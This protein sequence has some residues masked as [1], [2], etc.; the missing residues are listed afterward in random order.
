MV[1]SPRRPPHLCAPLLSA[2]IRYVEASAKSGRGSA[3]AFHLAV[4]LVRRGRVAEAD[5]ERKLKA[6]KGGFL[7]CISGC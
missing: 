3:E 5:R 4:R 6:M 1:V 2:L 7:S